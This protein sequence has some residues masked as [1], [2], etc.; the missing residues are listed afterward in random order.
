MSQRFAALDRK[1]CPLVIRLPW[2]GNKTDRMVKRI[3]DAVRLAYFAT[4]VC[5]AFKTTR[6]F[7]L[8]KDWLPTPSISNVVYLFECRQC[9]SQYVGKTSQRLGDRVKQ[10]VPRHLVDSGTE[11]SR[12]RGRPPKKCA[13]PGSDYQSVIACHLVSNKPYLE[14]YSD[15]ESYKI[16][17]R[18]RSR[19]HLDILEAMYI[20]HLKPVLCKQK[21]Y[22]SYLTLFQHAHSC[23]TTMYSHSH[24]S[25]NSHHSVSHP[26]V[27]LSLTSHA[28]FY[29]LLVLPMF[30]VRI[31]IILSSRGRWVSMPMS[32]FGIGHSAG[33]LV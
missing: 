10:H 24:T 7:S 6:A 21:T 17:T 27:H 1:P 8:P 22:V 26:H 31:I 9:E 5:A 25:P 12:K 2:L 30:V 4:E 16:L 19:S 15:F 11:Q 13:N 29:K 18:G 33:P 23:N 3:N 14:T 20:K 28:N 32:C